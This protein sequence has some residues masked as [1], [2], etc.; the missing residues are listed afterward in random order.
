[1]A[2]YVSN[3]IRD[4]KEI[5]PCTLYCVMCIVCLSVLCLSVPSGQYCICMYC[6]CDY[7]VYCDYVYCVCVY[8][9]LFILCVPTQYT[10]QTDN[11]HNTYSTQITRSTNIKHSTL[12]TQTHY[13][14][15]LYTVHTDTVHIDTIKVCT[16][17]TVSVYTVFVLPSGYTYFLNVSLHTSLPTVN[18]K[19]Q[20]PYHLI[21]TSLVGENILI[22]PC[23]IFGHG[24]IPRFKYFLRKKYHIFFQSNIR[25][26]NTTH[27]CFTVHNMNR[28]PNNSKCVSVCLCVCRR[29]TGYTERARALKLFSMY[30]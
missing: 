11:T 8:T 23:R 4:E 19:R 16:V 25:A 10:V 22:Y 24:T 15:T 7:Y 6:G 29:N 5:C 28:T 20:E 13:T 17:Y 3:S 12:Y 30:S 2:L 18:Y 27:Q 9:V 1:M 14:Q 26:W 21:L